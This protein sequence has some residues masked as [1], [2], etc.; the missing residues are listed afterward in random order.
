[1]LRMRGEGWLVRYPLG[2]RVPAAG[3]PLVASLRWDTGVQVRIGTEPRR[4]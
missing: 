2:N 4:R 1:M 3:V